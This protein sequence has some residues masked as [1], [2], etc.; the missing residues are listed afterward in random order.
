[1]L[2]FACGT[3]D[4]LNPRPPAPETLPAVTLFEP[5]LLL[6]ASRLGGPVLRGGV[7]LRILLKLRLWLKWKR[8]THLHPPFLL[9]LLQVNKL[10]AY[11]MAV[12]Y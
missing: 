2:S 3:R 1:M 9:R 10:G 6:A 11:D 12:F 8:G 7:C 4:K 5:L